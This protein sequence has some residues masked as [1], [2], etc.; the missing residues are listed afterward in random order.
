MTP[1][2]LSPAFK[3]YLWGG[4]RLRDEFH[5]DSALTPLAESW[6]LSCHPD[7]ESTVADGPFAGLK[8]SEYLEQAGRAALGKNCEKFTKFPIMIKLIDAKEPL[9][10]QV[11]PT[12][13]YAHRTGA[14]SKTE[15]WVVLDAV[16]GAKLIYGFKQPLTKEEFAARIRENRLLEAVNEE[17]V[18]PG[19]VFFIE[20]GTLHAIGG[21][22]LL[23]EIQQNSNVTYR[24][25]D[26][27]RLGPD[28]QPRALHTKE[29]A[30]VTVLAPAARAVG[31]QGRPEDHGDWQ[32]TLL[33]ACPYFTVRRIE[34]NNAFCDDP[35][36]DSFRAIL[37]LTEGLTLCADGERLPLHKGETV[38]VPADAAAY[39]VEGKGEFLLTT[40]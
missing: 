11:H 37:T 4:T 29:A 36:G 5:K 31:P 17:P 6:E 30:A 27:S 23:A 16:P 20:A 18:R 40:V 1:F 15:M 22:I 35:A 12:E 21:G 39:T 8:F 32:E 33:A 26:Y 34:T 24:V 10:I 9:S 25:Y 14:D 13:E 38:F 19:D 2:R 28:G 7:G 3:D